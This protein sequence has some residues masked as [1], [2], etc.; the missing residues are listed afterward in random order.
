MKTALIGAGVIGRVHA[1]ILASMGLD[2]CAICDTDADKARSL[3]A[4]FCLEARIYADYEELLASENIDVVHICT[5]HYLYAKQTVYALDRGVNVLCEKPLCAHPDELDAVLDAE[6]RSSA[7]LGVSQQ[8]R[9]NEATRFA[10]DFIRDNKPVDAHGSVCWH[11]DEKYFRESPWRGKLYEAGGG[12][13]INQALHT[14]DLAMLF[15]GMPSFVTA[16]IDT[17]IPQEGVEVEDTVNAFFDGDAKFS[18]YSTNNCEKNYPAE[19]KLILSDG[20][21]LVVLQKSVL[22]DGKPIFTTENE[23]VPVGKSYYENAHS[24]LFADFYDCVKNGRRF[25][26]DGEEAAKVMK[27]IFAVYESRGQKIQIK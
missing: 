24:A 21:E 19:V 20:R 5:P 26:I 14:L 8:N 23:T 12:S 3:A 22:L 10:L 13:L 25:P 15:C 27:L 17:L 11:R 4:E 16:K 6:K 18:F 2:V 7:I 1:K 9:Y